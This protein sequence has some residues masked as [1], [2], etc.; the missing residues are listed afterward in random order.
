MPKAIRVHKVGG[1]EVLTY[2]DVVTAKPGPGQVV[3][4]HKAVGLNFIDVY[5]RTG[6][7]PA[8]SMPF[9]LG[10][11]GAGD[12][13]ALGSGVTDFKVGDRVAYVSQ[14]GAYSEERVIDT[15]ILVKIPKAISY[16]TA[17]G[18]MLK[19][20]TA[21]YLLKR[22]FKVKA[23]Q[24]VLVHAAAGGTGQILCQW[25]KHLGATVIGTVGSKEKIKIAKAIGCDH[26][27]NS[28]TDNVAKRVREITKSV[29]CDVVY[30]GVGKATFA[31]SLDSL[32]QFG[33]MVSF[34]NAS[35]AVDAFNLGILAAKGS[36]Y[37]TR[38]TLFTHISNTDT[39]RAMA[40][41][42]FRVVGSGTVK[43]PVNHRYPLAKAADAHAA[44]EGRQTTGSVVLLP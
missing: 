4:K 3:V 11:E 40:R 38:P 23:G 21:E 25:A 8:A 5:F 10:N 31:A 2:E 35:G 37:I 14:L 18:M 42:L 1:P 26:V 27:L 24:T 15:R 36:L 28:S 12:I 22:T 17:A 13:I 34:G 43:V 30:D 33:T 41:N 6:L 20:L 32:R 19:G 7:Y 39:L 9:V 16:E 44:L 29:G